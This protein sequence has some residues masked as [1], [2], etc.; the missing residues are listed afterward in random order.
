MLRRDPVE[1]VEAEI[2]LVNGI[3]SMDASRRPIP[4]LERVEESR[5]GF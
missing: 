5:H 1:N 4:L 3:I 2:H